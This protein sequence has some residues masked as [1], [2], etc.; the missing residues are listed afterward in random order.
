[1]YVDDIIP[2][3]NDIDMLNAE[4]DML[5]KH[6]EMTDQGEIHFLLGMTIKRD[7]ES[8]TLFINKEKYIESVLDRF[9]MAECKQVSTPLEAT[10]HKQTEEEEGFD[11][12]LYQQAI[13]C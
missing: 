10:Y 4:K 13:G 8:K 5:C 9:D 7:R 11:K 2:V 12:N 6:F 1:M 3:S